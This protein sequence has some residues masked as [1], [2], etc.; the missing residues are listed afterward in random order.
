M[1]GANA[2][3]TAEA[4]Y[5]PLEAFSFS[6]VH[7]RGGLAGAPEHDLKQINFHVLVRLLLCR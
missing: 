2:K 6:F 4:L 5:A 1:P 7:I 3:P